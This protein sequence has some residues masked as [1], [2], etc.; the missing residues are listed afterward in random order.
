VWVRGKSKKFGPGLEIGEKVTRLRL[1]D[2]HLGDRY[3]KGFVHNSVELTWSDPDHHS[4][5]ILPPFL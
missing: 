1:S 4:P 3:K 5:T 2:G